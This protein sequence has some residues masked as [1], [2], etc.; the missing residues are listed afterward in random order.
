V[1]PEHYMKSCTHLVALLMLACDSPA[2]IE[3]PKA[4]IKSSSAPDA[5]SKQLPPMPARAGSSGAPTEDV[6]SEPLPLAEADEE[7]TLQ[8]PPDAPWVAGCRTAEQIANSYELGARW[9]TSGPL[10]VVK[11]KVNDTLNVRTSAS[12]LAPVVGQLQHDATGIRS[13]GNVCKAQGV[14]WYEVEFG[15][16]KG[17][18]NGGFVAQLTSTHDLTSDYR[19]FAPDSAESPE[20]FA[21][22]LV[23]SFNRKYSSQPEGKNRCETLGTRTLTSSAAVLKLYSCCELDDSIAGK[24]AEIEIVKTSDGWSF[25][26]AEGRYVCYRGAHGKLC[27]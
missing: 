17:W 25:Q 5:Q 13:T 18:V 9:M 19:E 14:T 1:R 2:A 7:S 11:V 16:R 10:G 6:A 24:Q 26:R 22:L 12:H 23:E 20:E 8:A 21:N 27:N 15:S 4:P 3:G